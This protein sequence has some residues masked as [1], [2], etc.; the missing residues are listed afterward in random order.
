MS[1]S[2]R[3]MLE[4]DIDAVMEVAEALAEAPRWGREAYLSAIAR[5]ST[6]RR[7][8]LV[9][10]AGETVVGFAVASLVA[11]EAELESIAVA[12]V[13]Q[14]R[15]VGGGLLKALIASVV[16]EG[17]TAMVLEV[18]ASN[19]AALGLYVRLGFA[20][21]GRRRGYYSDPAEDAVLMRLSF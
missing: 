11:G 15:G 2:V 12:F 4:A 3:P 10:L 6:L 21:E 18:R 1:F 20:E 5:D 16:R 7:I 14:K 8:A 17:C 19:F 13:E 9:A